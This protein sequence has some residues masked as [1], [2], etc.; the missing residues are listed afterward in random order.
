MQKQIAK[1]KGV[2]LIVFALLLMLVATTLFISRLDGNSIKIDRDK[3][4]AAALAEAKAA[5][6]GFAAKSGIASGTARPGELPCPDTD[7]NGTADGPCTANVI[8]RLPWKTLGIS[9]L[10]DGDGELLWYAVSTNFENNTRANPLN[11][12]TQGTI[13]LRDPAGA[14][15][16]NATLT[17]GLV[18]VV[19]APG[20]AITRQDAVVQVRNTPV[21]QNNKINYLD[22]ALGEE[23]NIFANGGLNGFIKGPIKDV[24]G[25]IILNDNLISITQDEL[26]AVVEPRVI[27]AVS[28]AL[29]D[30]YCG[31]GNADYNTKACVGAGG[32]RFFPLPA[33]FS[34]PSC[35]GAGN[36]SA[37][38]NSGAVINHGRIP[39]NP[40][41]GAWN[42]T[43]ILRGIS[44]NN[45]FQSNGWREQIHY[46][47]APACKFGTL[48]CGGAGGM[49]TLNFAVAPSSRIVVTAAGKP[50]SGQSRIPANKGLETHYIE[51]ENFVPL[52][53][54]YTKTAAGTFNDRSVNIP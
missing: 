45:W 41:S 49:L 24:S 52:D 38:C 22:N 29:L 47:V 19:I 10:R 27:A 16:N 23:N 39:A 3:K 17:N 18:A 43:S 11:S 30:Y 1:Q 5:L 4:T 37:V 36:V 34:D 53:N 46:A 6:I 31:S 9:D 2:A 21:N 14:I 13:T 32:N 12:E 15:L 50:L 42:A 25:N 35:L 44:V 8:G 51:D 28:N 20:I 7:N 40:N 54:V 48:N 33:S 26:M